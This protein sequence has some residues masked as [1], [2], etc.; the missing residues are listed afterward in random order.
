VCLARR[1]RRRP[2]KA[3]RLPAKRG[4]SYS[5]VRREGRRSGTQS[6]QMRNNCH[7]MNGF[8]EGAC[9]ASRSVDAVTNLSEMRAKGASTD[10]VGFHFVCKITKNVSSIQLS[11]KFFCSSCGL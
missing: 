9:G 2:D 7:G 3:S 10:A 4:Q 11:D 5:T 8:C 6:G 1:W